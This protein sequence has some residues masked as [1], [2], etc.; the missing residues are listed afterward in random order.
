MTTF[1]NDPNEI[2]MGF[3]VTAPDSYVNSVELFQESNSRAVKLVRLSKADGPNETLQI[4]FG[5]FFLYKVSRAVFGNFL[6][7][8]FQ[9]I[10]RTCR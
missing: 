6:A 3:P 10:G 9:Q 7:R 2:E 4:A 1:S 8:L 5:L